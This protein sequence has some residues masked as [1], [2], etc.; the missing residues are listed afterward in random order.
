MKLPASRAHVTILLER[1]SAIVL[2]LDLLVPRSGGFCSPDVVFDE[3][4]LDTEGCG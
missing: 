2:I 4:K 1:E 3:R